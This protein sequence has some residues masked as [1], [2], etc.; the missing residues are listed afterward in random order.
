M[1]GKGV[2]MKK[3]PLLMMLTGA[4]TTL[5]WAR[6]RTEFFPQV[7]VNTLY[8]QL[9]PEATKPDTPSSGSTTVDQLEAILRQEASDVQVEQGQV[10][11]KYEGQTMLILTSA[12]HNRMRI[13]API[14]KAAEITPEQR[15]NMLLAN[16]HSA[17]DGR[18]AVS[19]GIVF[20]TFL[21]PLSSLQ[22][23][24]F[25]SA[26]SQVNQLVQNFGT[27]YSSG[28]LGF[29]VSEEKPEPLPAI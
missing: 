8:A 14:K 6:A 7:Q 3:L 19:N 17:L 10:S 20:A 27:T 23:Q 9:L 4:V 16:F 22:E 5:V 12:Q 29:G 26:L 25:R 18:Y 13:I 24:D 2:A 21:H 15:D 11:F 28:A 1:T